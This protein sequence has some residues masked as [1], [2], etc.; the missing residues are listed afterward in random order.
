ME[1]EFYENMP[2]GFCIIKVPKDNFRTID[3]YDIVYSNEKFKNFFKQ[4]EQAFKSKI[5]KNK[6]MLFDIAYKNETIDEDVYFDEKNK[7]FKITLFKYEEGSIVC[8]LKDKTDLYFY[9]KALQ[10]N[11]ISFKSIYFINLKNDYFYSI[12]ID[13]MNIKPMGKYSKFLEDLYKNAYFISDNKDEI[14]C[15]FSIENLIKKLTYKDSIEFKYQ[16]KNT[17]NKYEW[18]LT[19]ISIVDRKDGIPTSATMSI[20][21]IDEIVANQEQQR[22]LLEEAL[23]Q[24]EFA[25]NTKMNFLTSM[26]H[27]IRTPLN[28]IIGMTA[29][30]EM[31]LDNPEKLKDCFSKIKLSSNHLLDLANKVL[32]MSKFD[33]G[34]IILNEKKFEIC[35]YIE[36]ISKRF[37]SSVQE[38][39]Q[40][41]NVNVHN[42]DEKEVIGDTVR[43][44]QV[45]N[46]IME[47]A[48]KFTHEGGTI[49]LDI[50][51]KKSYLNGY[52]YYEFIFKDNGIGMEKDFIENIFKPFARERDSIADN[53]EG[54]GLGLP[55]A[56]HIIKMM[57]GNIKV[58]SDVGKGSKFVVEFYL[59]VNEEETYEIDKLSQFST[60]IFDNSQDTYNKN[61]LELEN[62]GITANV[63]ND[64]N[65]FI[66]SFL[67]AKENNNPY[68]LV[69]IDNNVIDVFGVSII[70]D[71]QEVIKKRVP[72]VISY[73]FGDTKIIKDKEVFINAGVTAFIIK[74]LFVYKFAYSLKQIVYNFKNSIENEKLLSKNKYKDKNV[75]IVEDNEINMEI[76]ETIVKLK[77]MKTETA[78][79][80]QEA[81]DKIFSLPENHFDF[82][83]MDIQM[84]I[85]DGYEATEIIRK[86][87]RADLEKVPIIAITANAFNSD[88][89]KSKDF[90]M[91]AH[92]SKPIIV[93][94]FFEVLDEFI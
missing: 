89:Q 25:K 26:S 2:Y 49:S 19:S 24:A 86:S 13:S 90:G 60:L 17:D 44:T 21:N 75:L 51:E 28:I 9:Q 7:F 32:D 1:T 31:N 22:K 56:L 5:F 70:E 39:N 35:K 27:D 55:I 77:G 82:I 69:I 48:I 4:D 58:F 33:S 59:K 62:V 18:C 57:Y 80:G 36:D 94:K 63:V 83:L 92:I 67:Q 8:I 84:P 91:N 11:I 65:T 74:S 88:I 37:F 87:K 38:K 45:F 40:K 78:V 30:A 85:M 43:L 29:I 10:S 81:V 23:T 20:K 73:P 34:K 71:L 68:S 76:I 53:L 41:F 3:E 66:S 47:N 79:N 15:E 46:N 54:T 50:Y 72:I 16:R 6:E 14:F 42:I 64:K 61:Y 12:S 93:E 52:N